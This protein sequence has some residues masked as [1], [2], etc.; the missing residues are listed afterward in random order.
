MRKI[1]KARALSHSY[2]SMPVLCD[3]SLEVAAGESIAI[4]GASG[5]GK[6]SLIHILG[7]LL[8][9]DR[10]ELVICGQRVDRKNRISLRRECLG[11]VFQDFFLLEEYSVWENILLP[12]SLSGKRGR[13]RREIIQRMEERLSTFSLLEKRD[14]KP[15]TLSGGEKQRVALLRALCNSP[16]L[17]L[18]DEPTGNLDRETSNAI[19]PLLIEETKREK[20]ALIFATHDMQLASCC[21][22]VYSLEKGT[23]RQIA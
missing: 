21:R 8:E 7:T 17:L 2:G 5:E 6:S 23:L 19:F 16:S 10:G 12:A 4:M 11:F 18:A 22:R 13:T 14:V 1:L 3:L 15:A 20:R 9:P